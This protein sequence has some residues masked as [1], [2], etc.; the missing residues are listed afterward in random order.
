MKK[1]WCQIWICPMENDWFCFISIVWFQFSHKNEK[2]WFWKS[3]KYFNFLIKKHSATFE[4]VPRKNDWFCFISIVG[5]H[6]IHKTEKFQF[7][8]S[9]KYFNV[10]DKRMMSDLIMPYQ[11]LIPFKLRCSSEILAILWEIQILN[12]IKIV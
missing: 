3:L 6:F 2:F 5:V 11:C 7:W 8:S 12:F 1:I 9:L 4:Y 10:F